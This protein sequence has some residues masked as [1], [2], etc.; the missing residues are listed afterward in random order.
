MP[1]SET[2]VVQISPSPHPY[3]STGICRGQDKL[4]ESFGN[5]HKYIWARAQHIFAHC[6]GRLAMAIRIAILTGGGVAWALGIRTRSE[7][8]V[9]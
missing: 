1:R 2:L 8:L 4:S 6:R 3:S 9:V 7:P 5:A